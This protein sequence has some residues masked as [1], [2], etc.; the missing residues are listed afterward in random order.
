MDNVSAEFDIVIAVV[1]VRQVEVDRVGQVEVIVIHQVEVSIVG[2][3]KLCEVI[4][5]PVF[6]FTVFCD[7][8]SAETK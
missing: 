6:F 8:N 7:K 1:K 5:V 3:V 2:P 4:M